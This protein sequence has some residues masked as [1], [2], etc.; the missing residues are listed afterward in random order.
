M[1]IMQNLRDRIGAVVAAVI[2]AL[3]ACVCGAVMTFYLAPRQALEA[4]RIGNLPQMNA[5][6][7]SSSAAGTEIMVT[8]SLSDNAALFDDSDLVAYTLHEWVVTYSED[9]D[10]NE[11]VDGSWNFVETTVPDLNLNVGGQVLKVLAASQPSLD[12]NL[13]EEFAYTDS[14]DVADDGV[15][16]IP[17]GSQRYK[18]FYDGDLVTVLGQKS[19]TGGVIPEKLFAG[20]RVAF[21]QSEVDAA[22]GLLMGGIA[23]M[24][25]APV[26]LIGGILG[27]IFGRRKR[28]VLG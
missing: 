23:F 2:G 28:G 25:C 7:V 22:K 18:G 11:T 3:M 9:S 17:D 27:A 26:I 14:L 20:D 4:N 21:E 10:G 13:R 1:N 15:E 16:S 8:G 6:H 24:A 5:E 12:G 19:S